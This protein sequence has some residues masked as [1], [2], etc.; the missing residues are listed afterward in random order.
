[1]P[2]GRHRNRK[3]TPTSASAEAEELHE[4]FGSYF[5]SPE[6]AQ[7]AIDSETGSTLGLT[8]VLSNLKSH[9]GK[10]LSGDYG[11]VGDTYGDYIIGDVDQSGELNL[12]DT[13]TMLKHYLGKETSPEVTEYIENTYLPIRQAYQAAPVDEREGFDYASAFPI[14][15][16]SWLQE[17]IDP[18]TDWFGNVYEDEWSSAFHYE[19]QPLRGRT[20]IREILDEYSYDKQYFWNPET[21]MVDMTITAD[22]TDEG[23]IGD[24]LLSFPERFLT[25]K[26]RDN[27]AA[28][29]FNVQDGEI[30]NLSSQGTTGGWVSPV[31]DVYTFSYTPDEFA[32]TFSKYGNAQFA[33]ISGGWDHDLKQVLEGMYGGNITRDDYKELMASLSSGTGASA[34]VE[35]DG[36]VVRYDFTAGDNGFDYNKV[37]LGDYDYSGDFADTGLGEWGE[38][39]VSRLDTGGL[40]FDPWSLE[41][42]RT[43][44]L[45]PFKDKEDLL[46]FDDLGLAYIDTRHAKPGGT[47][48]HDLAQRGWYGLS[49]DGTVDYDNYYGSRDSIL[50]TELERQE[51][52]DWVDEFVETEG[53]YAWNDLRGLL[54]GEDESI[55]PEEYV[56]RMIETEAYDPSVYYSKDRDEAVDFGDYVDG[57][58]VASAST[59]AMDRPELTDMGY[60]FASTHVPEGFI[61]EADMP[62]WA[63]DQG[64]YAGNVYDQAVAD[65]TQAGIEQGREGYVTQDFYDTGTTAATQAGIE[66]GRV[67][68]QTDEA[69]ALAAA[70]AASAAQQDIY[71]TATGQGQFIQGDEGYTWENTPIRRTEDEFVAD[72]ASW[73]GQ[74]D[75]VQGSVLPSYIQG[76]GDDDRTSLYQQLGVVPRRQMTV[77]SS[78][79]PGAAPA[80]MP[81]V[82]GRTPTTYTPPAGRYGTI[83]Q[84]QMQP[85]IA[86][87]MSGQGFSGR[88]FAVPIPRINAPFKRFGE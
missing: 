78:I 65:A 16:P 69:A 57:N 3:G 72:A 11:F 24:Y 32:D 61:S 38:V 74:N 22:R 55:T 8:D 1:M 19:G 46:Y 18:T 37:D 7:A 2:L 28:Q 48:P 77:G 66:Q 12:T 83:Q 81:R 4:A 26:L 43:D 6:E 41:A 13:L 70:N 56:Q 5:A 85:G 71:G 29:Y 31:K 45:N 53:D 27:T 20:S 23:S 35:E 17:F 47:G 79:T 52:P 50:E 30:A 42:S 80:Y 44:K 82:A 15:A 76:M 10:D 68:Y 14:D 25:D 67:G 75:Y 63:T 51:A 60:Q 36:R 34:E 21:G 58:W 49:S 84:Q 64:Y 86:S 88:G 54:V 62:Q 9:L 40:T 33:E 73:A 39:G 59:M 87:L